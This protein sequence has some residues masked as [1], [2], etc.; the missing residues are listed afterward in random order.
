[1]YTRFSCITVCI[2][3]FS[4]LVFCTF[5]YC[6]YTNTVIQQPHTR[7]FDTYQFY[8]KLRKPPFLFFAVVRQYLVDTSEDIPSTW[9]LILNQWKY[10]N[11]LVND[12]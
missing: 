9:S 12:I 2:P 8:T 1:M 5:T 4:I 10:A 6:L 3:E 11:F 7:I